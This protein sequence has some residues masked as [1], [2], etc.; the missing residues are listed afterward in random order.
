MSEAA[1]HQVGMFEI[2]TDDPAQ[3]KRIAAAGGG[4]IVVGL[5]LVVLN[6]VVPLFA[7][8]YDGGNVVFGLFGLVVVVLATNPTYEA[9][10]RLDEGA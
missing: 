6:L 1:V 10:Q 5:V 2:R 9:A 3:L 7:G 4:G 8:G